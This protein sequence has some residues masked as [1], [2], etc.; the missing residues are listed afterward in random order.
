MADEKPKAEKSGDVLTRNL[1]K[2]VLALLLELRHTPDKWTVE[3]KEKLL[4]DLR[5][6]V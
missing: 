4:A 6:L 5:K 2:T 3:Q 1:K